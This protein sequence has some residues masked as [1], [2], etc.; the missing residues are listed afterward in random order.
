[1]TG[2]EPAVDAGRRST[3]PLAIDP[4]VDLPDE[5]TITVAE[6]QAAAAGNGRTLVVLDDDPTGT[7][8]VAD[9]PVLTRWAV[10]DLRWAFACG[11][12]ACYVLTNTRSL[13]AAETVDRN[14]AVGA[15]A[16]AAAGGRPLTFVSRSDSTLR[17]HF[18]LEPAA[19]AD[20]I[21][22]HGR[23]VDGIV[24]VPAFPDAG[25]VT[26]D[27][28]HYVVAADGRWQPAAATEFARDRT[29]GY[30]SS[31]LADFV[32]E[33]S[34]GEIS[35]DQV[36]HV[37]LG[38]V[39]SG[40]TAVAD[41]LSGVRSRTPVVVDIVSEQDLRSL[42]LGVMEAERRGQT[43]LYRVGPPFVRTRIGQ[44]SRAPLTTVEIYPDPAGSP[45]GG[46]VVVG[47]HTDLTNRQVDHLLARRPMPQWEVDAQDVAQG[48]RDRRATRRL[49]AEVARGLGQG[50]VVLQTSRSLATAGDPTADLELARRVSEVLVEVVRQVYAERRPRFV[51]A[52]GGITSSDIATAALG[53]S[54]AM[55]RGPLLPGLVSLWEPRGGPA[56]GLPFIVFPGNVGGESALTDVVRI[57]SP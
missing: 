27:G 50:D 12:P 25:R 28:T 35:A 11:K 41:A 3:S 57:L 23:P 37:P 31:R 52:K 1:M 20:E 13:D 47:S 46:L 36:R 32:A 4:P 15:N 17:G 38:T 30:R 10:D 5:T 24:I 16:T 53:I 34:R 55:V 42:A 45:A 54:R 56:D 48:R 8:A 21:E 29:F 7:Q 6:L 9:V 49:A 40:A 22:R 19:L 51:L 14:R 26:L 43:L 44:S 39:R 2:V 33:K 18:P